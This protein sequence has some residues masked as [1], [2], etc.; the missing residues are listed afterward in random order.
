MKN[1]VNPNLLEL[2]PYK[3]GKPVEELQRAYNLDRIVKLASNENPFQ[4]P[5]NVKNKIREEIDNISTYPCSDSY[6][7]RMAI[8]EKSGL[9]IDNIMVGAGSVE[10]TKMIT[11]AFLNLGEKVLTSEK[12]F[13]M[14]RIAAIETQGAVSFIEAEMDSEFR[15]SLRNIMDKIDESV[16]IIFLTNPNNPTGTI[17]DGK[18]IAKFIENVPEN[19]LIILDNAYEEYVSKDADYLTGLEY[20]NTKKNVIVLR[21]F[22]K[23]YGLA[24]LRIGY[25]LG[26]PETLSMLSRV[27]APFNVTRIAQN[28]ALESLKSD[29]FKNKSY[30]LNKKNKSLLLS[31]MSALGIK[32]IP[33]ETNFLM[34]FPETDVSE[35]NDKLLKE[36]VIIRP[37]RAFGVPDAMRVTIGFEE[38]NNFFLEKLKKVLGL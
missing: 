27:K 5:E 14:Y 12:T 35:L 24:G 25:A 23:V 36:G 31:Q 10:I 1:L 33:S 34:F 22:S 29:D 7:L 3:P 20:I 8:A 15:F 21:T 19:I 38:D 6:Y 4:I 13:L 28:A 2:M 32:T 16:K 9:G 18:E 37:L 17:V 26:H 11:R 30:E